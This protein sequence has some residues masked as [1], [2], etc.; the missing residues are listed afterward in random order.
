MFTIIRTRRWVGVMLLIAAALC[1]KACTQPSR[2]AGPKPVAATPS[3]AVQPSRFIVFDARA[4]RFDHSSGTNA[5]MKTLRV[6]YGGE[7]FPKVP[8]GAAP[9]M[10]EPNEPIVHQLGESLYADKI[11]YAC[12]DLEHWPMRGVDD[13]TIEQSMTKMMNIMG[14][15]R[16]E[17]PDCKIGCYGI[18]PLRDYW[19]ALKGPEHPGYQA[20]VAENK[21]LM[22]FGESS[23][24]LFPSI[25][26]FYEDQEG[27]K[28]YAIANIQQAKQYGKPVY[29]F[30]WPQYHDSNKKLVGRYVPV[31]FWR[32]QLEVC[33]EYADGVCIWGYWPNGFDE[34][35]PWWQET[36]RFMKDKG[37]VSN[38]AKIH[39]AD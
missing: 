32:M 4:G 25:Y 24:I 9:D 37:L 17:A 22:K 7:F 5:G 8:G 10:T 26:T 21:R 6:L 15:L 31:E 2:E 3:P 23:D 19:R 38:A 28:K 34:S 35:L 13:A 11:A 29:P 12:V 20:W 33:Y 27:W 1:A 18:P 39:D 30:I 16:L 14:W 36:L